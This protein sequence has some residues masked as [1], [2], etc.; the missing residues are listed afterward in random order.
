MGGN[1][2]SFTLYTYIITLSATV[3][4]NHIFFCCCYFN[5]NEPPVFLVSLLINM[6]VASFT[7]GNSSVCVCVCVCVNKVA[8]DQTA[9]KSAN[10]WKTSAAWEAPPVF[11]FR[12][13]FLQDTH[14]L[15]SRLLTVQI[16]FCKRTQTR[17]QL[18]FF[19]QQQKG[20]CEHYNI[21]EDYFNNKTVTQ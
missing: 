4:I 5:L 16:K 13:F 12:F 3:A 15:C 2:L 18:F 20:T 7:M 21:H 6:K 11:F 8:I 10:W 17:K 14:C 1:P 9:G 19:W